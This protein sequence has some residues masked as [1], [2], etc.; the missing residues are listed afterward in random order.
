M[1]KSILKYLF[2]LTDSM[3][4]QSHLAGDGLVSLFLGLVL[5]ANK[6]VSFRGTKVIVD[7]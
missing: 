5:D 7:F 1:H 4:R 6:K 2:L 3:V